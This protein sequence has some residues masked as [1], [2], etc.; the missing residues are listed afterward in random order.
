MIPLLEIWKNT[1]IELLCL[2]FENYMQFGVGASALEDQAGF[3]ALDMFRIF[4][5]QDNNHSSGK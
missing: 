3:P 1:G 5:F 4:S 2:K